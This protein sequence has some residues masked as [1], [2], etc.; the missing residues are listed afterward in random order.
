[1]K[2]SPTCKT[3]W[4]RGDFD[5]GRLTVSVRDQGLGVPVEEQ[6]EIFRKFVRG[7]AT[8]TQVVKGTGLGLALVQQIVEA[9]GG[10]VGLES[11]VGEGS[12]FSM[13][14]P[15]AVEAQEQS[16]WLAS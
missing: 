13:S 6:R 4:V 11:S 7:A 16:K 8:S 12:T 15:A 1:M 14:L 2:Y 10:I 3:I 5:G 9:H